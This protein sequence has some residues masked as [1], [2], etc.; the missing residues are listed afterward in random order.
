MEE[1]NPAHDAR[2]PASVSHR[3]LAAWLR[4]APAEPA[5]QAAESAGSGA[6]EQDERTRELFAEWER[7]S[8]RLLAELRR[9]GPGVQRDR[10]P[11][12]LMAL[13]ALQ[14]H[15]AMAIQAHAASEGRAE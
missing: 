11:R 14:A 6:I 10:T 13:G 8:R 12:Q 3:E 5:P 15:L 7:C 2:I 4:Q 9:A 1:P